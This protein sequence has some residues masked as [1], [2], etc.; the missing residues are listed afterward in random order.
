MPQANYELA[1]LALNTC[2]QLGTLSAGVEYCA[3]QVCLGILKTIVSIS[4]L[5]AQL[6]DFDGK[7][8]DSLFRVAERLPLD[9]S[10]ID[11]LLSLAQRSDA[12]IQTAAT[13]L[14]KHIQ[15]RNISLTPAQVTRVIEQFCSSGPW[16]SR[17]HIVQM[18]PNVA[19]PAA[20]TEQLFQSLV[21][22]VSERNKFIRAWVYTALHTLA[23]QH[24]NYA[25]EVIPLLDQAARDEAAS[26]RARLRQLEP[27]AP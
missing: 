14:L 2:K 7:H 12:P 18:L 10:T 11:Q 23:L 16:E 27:L 15:S 13:W 17:L 1:P 20:C 26:V 3:Y 25:V 22:A 5:E 6:Q 9:G 19:I 21:A 4:Q 8:V 24:R